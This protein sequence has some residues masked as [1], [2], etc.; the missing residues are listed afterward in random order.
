MGVI[1]NF[2]LREV[3][4]LPKTSSLYVKYQFVFFFNFNFK[5][6]PF[7][8][9]QGRSLMP[10]C[11]ANREMAEWEYCSSLQSDLRNQWENS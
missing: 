10:I 6:E 5:T 2:V 7:N 1:P 3:E 4:T 8:G 9:D 11:I